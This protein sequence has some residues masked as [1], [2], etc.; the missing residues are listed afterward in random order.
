MNLFDR[1]TK[2]L[3]RIDDGAATSEQAYD[4]RWVTFTPSGLIAAGPF[5]AR[6]LID[7]ATMKLLIA[8]EKL[9]RFTVEKL[10]TQWS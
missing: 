10:T 8:V 9:T 4:Y 5:G 6:Y 3:A 7:P 2:Q 1:N